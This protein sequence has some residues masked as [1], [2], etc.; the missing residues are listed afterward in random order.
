[1][2]GPT[3]PPGPCHSMTRSALMPTATLR[4]RLT[5]IQPSPAAETPGWTHPRIH[6]PT[7]RPAMGLPAGDRR[8]P[9]IGEGEAT[10]AEQELLEAMQEY[11][12]RSGR[13]FPTWSEVL[14]VLQSLGYQKPDHPAA[15]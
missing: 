2:H 11:K 12:R 4:S 1:M 7:L 13:L 9:S 15:P 5:P 14:E 10:A 8:H 3:M 6:V